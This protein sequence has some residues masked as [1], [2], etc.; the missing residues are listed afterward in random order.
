MKEN[1]KVASYQKKNLVNLK[2]PTEILGLHPLLGKLERA[3]WCFKSRLLNKRRNLVN[4]LFPKC[5]KK[6]AN[7]PN[8]LTQTPKMR[9]VKLTD[10]D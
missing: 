8:R 10:F 2:G 9:K 7:E 5:P 4:S 6:D 3:L 1:I